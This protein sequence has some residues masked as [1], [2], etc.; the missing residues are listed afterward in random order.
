M[1]GAGKDVVT[2]GDMFGEDLDGDGAV[3]AGV[4]GF[5]DFAYAAG[6][7]GRNDFVGAEFV[8]SGKRR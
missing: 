4:A 1:F 8:A 2:M 7:D 6:T 5:V 3:E